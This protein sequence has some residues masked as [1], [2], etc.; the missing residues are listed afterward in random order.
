[1]SKLP[2]CLM[3]VTAQVDTAVEDEWNHWY[4]TVHLPEILD[5]PGFL[6]A[7]RYVTESDGKREY[8]TIYELLSPDAMAGET[9]N[10]RRG[11]YQFAASVTASVRLFTVARKEKLI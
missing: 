3:V 10:S 9:F 1:M 2:E 5:C 6:D 7:R 11:W 4:D 8:I